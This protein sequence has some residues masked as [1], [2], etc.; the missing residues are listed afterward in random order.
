M[1]VG[2]IPKIT[3]GV[4]AV[5]ILAYFGTRQFIS[6][7]EDTSPSVEVVTS[8]ESINSVA[9]TDAIPKGAV[10]ATSRE[11]KLKISAEEMQ[12]D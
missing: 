6:S 7:K 8:T 5:V 11:D 3:A 12:A 4:V 9:Q 10:T 2:T 1:K